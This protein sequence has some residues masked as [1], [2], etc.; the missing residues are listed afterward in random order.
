MGGVGAEV[1]R[2]GFDDVLAREREAA[3]DEDR[4]HFVAL[5]GGLEQ[6][7]ALELRVAVLLDDEEALV[8]D[9]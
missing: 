4:A 3:V 2:H 1:A 9:A 6:Q 7:Q 5:H 8:G